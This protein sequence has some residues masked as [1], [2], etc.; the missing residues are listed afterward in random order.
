MKLATQIG[1]TD[2][3]TTLPGDDRD[4]PVWDYLAI[5]RHRK[6]IEDAG[7]RWSVVESVPISDRIKLGLDGRDED[8]DHYCKTVRN[9]G[10]AGIRVMCYNWMAVFNWMRTSVSTRSRGGALATSYD[11]SLMENAPLTEHGEVSEDLLWDTLQYFLERV[12]PVAEE[13]GVKQGMHPDDP[14]L[15]PI[16]GIS[17]IMTN[18]DAYERLFDLVPSEVN[19][20]TFC[21]G[22]FAA[23]GV[24]VPNTIRSFGKRNKIFFAHYRDIKGAV[25]SFVEA[26]HDDGDTDMAE[27]MRAY[28]D[29]GFEGP[30]RPD[31]VPTLEGEPNDPPGYTLMGRLFAVGY[32][33]GVLDGI[34]G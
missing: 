12:I 6:R 21:Q 20:V 14:P 34:D 10:A 16:R 11:N 13:A 33:K 4:G 15:S 22:N 2:I 7:L 26:F 28:R 1:I 24:D 5:V 8:I 25:P 19:G 9:L 31:H 27:C 32:M 29:V 17:R 30:I 3:V 23:M 18:V